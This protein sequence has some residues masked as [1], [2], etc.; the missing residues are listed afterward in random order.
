[1]LQELALKDSNKPAW[2]GSS[3]YNYV[4]IVIAADEIDFT[5]VKLLDTSIICL[6]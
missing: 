5:M 1:M 4:R 6:G 2:T 3:M